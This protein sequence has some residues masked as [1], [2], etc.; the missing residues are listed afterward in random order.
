MNKIPLELCMWWEDLG[1]SGQDKVNL[2][3]GGLT[4]LLKIRP[5]G[6]II[7]ALVTFW[8]P[9]HNVF[10]FSDFELTPTL[11]EI[12]GYIGSA[13]VP[14]RH[15]YLVAPRVFAVHRFLDS[16][17]ISR[18]VHNPDLEAGFS[19]L[20]FIYQRYGHIGNRLKWEEHRCFA[21]MVVFLGLLVFP[22]NIWIAG[23]VSTLLTQAKS[24]LAPLIV[25]EIFR[26]L[27][28]CKAGGDFFEGC[29]LLLQMWMIEHLCH[30]PQYMSYGSTEKNCIEE[31]YTRIDGCSLPEGVTE[32][33]SRLRSITADQI[34]WTFG[35]LPVDE[36]IYMP[37]IGPH[38]LLMGLRC[39][40]PYAPY[41][42]LKQAG[43]MSNSS[44]R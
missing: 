37:A 22:R 8:D 38:F 15:K 9:A 36:I 12:A 10:N 24:T 42:V 13:E 2:Y 31:F 17:K 41:R 19:T 3:L 18:R 26:A 11:E 23:V 6:D 21:F 33:I 35:W 32:W 28:A 43:E 30:R 20:Q 7:K 27:T 39:I 34:E 29:N 4:G 1:K 40:Q 44:R 25:S 5:R 14:L 16:L